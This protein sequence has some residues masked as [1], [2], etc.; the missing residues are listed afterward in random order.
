MSR[1]GNAIIE[2]P[3]KVELKVGGDQATVKGPLGEI[4]FGIPA[5]I[6]IN[7]DGNTLSVVRSDD[8][9]EQRA[10]HGLT[11]ALL[12]NHVKGVS[13]G[14]IK[15]LELNGVGYRVALKGKQLVLS[16]GFSHE[17]HYDLP[18]DV[19]A[20]VEQSKIELKSIDKQK[21]G[22]AASEIRAFRRPEPYKGKGIRYSNEVIR[23]KAGKAGKSGKGGKK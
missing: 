19:E 22:Q 18:A 6:S 12:N 23:R 4:Q 7:Q 15:S 5:G 8:S 1:I 17:I 13:V 21:V 16:L 9:K 11:R 20:K 3:A 10:Y 2:M 14:W